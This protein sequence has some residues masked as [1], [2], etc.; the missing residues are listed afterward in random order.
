MTSAFVALGT[1]KARVLGLMS[2]TS[3]D[4]IAEIH[5]AGDEIWLL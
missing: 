4:A 2:G 1:E 3:Y 5:P